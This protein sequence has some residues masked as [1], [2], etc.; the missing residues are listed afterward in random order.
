MG[1]KIRKEEE[2]VNLCASSAFKEAAGSGH[3]VGAAST[4]HPANHTLCN[5]GVFSDY[6][7]LLWHIYY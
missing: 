7:G 1:D 5:V 3:R 2:S 6:L 4:L